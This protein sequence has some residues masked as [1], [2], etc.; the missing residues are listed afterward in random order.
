MRCVCESWR[1]AR[2]CS[3]GKL[4]GGGRVQVGADDSALDSMFEP[5]WDAA[6]EFEWARRSL[7][8]ILCLKRDLKQAGMRW[9]SSRG[10]AARF[11]SRRMLGCGGRVQ[12]GASLAP[13]DS[14][15]D[16]SWDALEEFKCARR[17]LC[18]IPSLKKD[19][20]QAGMQIGREHV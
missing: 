11:F 12:V 3:G 15:F 4:G 1:V 5:S 18:P 16:A 20:K 8:S 6:V 14:V 17:S 13:L 2:A 7:C 10:R 19:L 9:K